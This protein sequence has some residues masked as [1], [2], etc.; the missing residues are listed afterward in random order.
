MFRNILFITIAICLLSVGIDANAQVRDTD[1]TVTISPEFPSPNEEVK[2][3][4]GSFV[5]DLEKAFIGWS[6]NGDTVATGVGKTD[7]M[8]NTEN[9]SRILLN[10]TIE[11]VQNQSLVKNIAIVPAYVDLVWEGVDSYS[12]P[13][14]KGR[15]LVASEGKYKI[16]AIPSVSASGERVHNA[17][18]SY[19]WIKDGTLERKDSGWGE[20]SFIFKN[21][22]LDTG[23]NVRVA[24]SDVS[25]GI[26]TQKEINLFPSTPKILF[27]EKNPILGIN[28]GESIKDG[29]FVDKDG[30]TI[31]AVPYYISS[32][33]LRSSSLSW[34]WLLGG[35]NFATPSTPN[36][37]SI[38]PESNRRGVSSIELILNKSQDLFTETSKKIDVEF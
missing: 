27:Y 11:T 37:M 31:E 25:N 16:V 12:P 24:I 3:Q 15:T 20:D 9:L 4:I 2:V 29:Y 17:N 8:F 18:L 13:F 19:D 33:D 7:Y 1:I 28:L 14:Y 5:T 26:S 22:Y 10:I 35:Q 36:E 38:R 21:S 34:Q 6:L 30:I 23:N 32:K